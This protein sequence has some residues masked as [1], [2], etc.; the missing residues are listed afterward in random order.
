MVKILLLLLFV[1][2]LIKQLFHKCLVQYVI[3][4]NKKNERTNKS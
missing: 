2:S 3:N 1:I 4:K